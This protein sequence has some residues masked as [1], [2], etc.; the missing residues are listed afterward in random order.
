MLRRRRSRRVVFAVGEDHIRVG[1]GGRR[2]QRRVS[3]CKCCR[4]CTRCMHAAA[5]WQESDLLIL[6]SRR[7]RSAMARGT[8]LTVDVCT[9]VWRVQ[10]KKMVKSRMTGR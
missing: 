5:H 9:G 1:E 8:R 2:G 6:P 10:K 7:W 4:G 3:H